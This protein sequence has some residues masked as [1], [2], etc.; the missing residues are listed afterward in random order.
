MRAVLTNFGTTGDIQPFVALAIEF[1]RHE[2][3][4]AHV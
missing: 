1:R 4:R 3:G 2:I